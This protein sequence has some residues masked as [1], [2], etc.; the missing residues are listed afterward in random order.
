MRI[1]VVDDE[2]TLVSFLVPVLE[3]HGYEVD[4]VGTGEEALAAVAERPPD[5]VL[6]DVALPGLDGLAVCRALR[7]G[8][9]HLPVILLTGLASRADELA[10]F[11]ALADDY[12]T[13][14]LSPDTLLARVRALLRRVAAGDPGA[15]VLRFDRIEVDLAA[16]EARR[17]GR[18][19]PLT[20]KEFALLAFLAEHP[21]RT[22]G[23]SQ[24]L[25][26]VW[27]VDFTGSTATVTQHVHR[28]RAALEPDPSRPRYLLTRPGVGYLFSRPGPR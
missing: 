1:L 14:P 18:P 6:L 2:P 15:R 23:H 20:R 10:G 25:V 16:R 8:P 27:G 24:L 22:F 4:A 26:Q 12:V 21:G 28:L 19:V 17:D 7:R 5:L 11:A 3:R 9:R 13:K